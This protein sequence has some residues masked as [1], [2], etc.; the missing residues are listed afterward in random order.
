VLSEGESVVGSG[1]L[2]GLIWPVEFLAVKVPIR[3]V[4]SRSGV[5]ARDRLTALD[6]VVS[7]VARQHLI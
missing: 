4:R 2:V 6:L 1:M 3:K 7:F 5:P